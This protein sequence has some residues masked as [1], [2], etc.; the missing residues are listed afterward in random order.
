MKKAW[1]MQRDVS[2]R[3]IGDVSAFQIRSWD[4]KTKGERHMRRDKEEVH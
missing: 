4:G 2:K 3:Y 1:C